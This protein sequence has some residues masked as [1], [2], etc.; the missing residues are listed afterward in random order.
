LFG[1]LNTEFLPGLP[2]HLVRGVP[3]TPP[4]LSLPELDAAIGGYIPGTYHARD[5]SETGTPPLTAWLASGWLPRMPES[6]EDLDLLLVMV[7][8][9]R[10][11]HRDG[12]HFQGLRYLDPTLAGYV[13]EP[14]T[15]RYDP[16]DIAEIRVFYRNQ[17]LCR[18]ISPEHAGETITLKDIQAARSAHRR[19]LRGQISERVARVADFLPAPTSDPTPPQGP[20]PAQ[21]KTAPPLRTYLEDTR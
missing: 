2:G 6:L 5:H 7:A 10:T 8:R 20:A 13:G 14:V 16:R 17:F 11:V 19:A 12:I 9:P 21:R 15:I 3:A 1:T 4:R 18:A